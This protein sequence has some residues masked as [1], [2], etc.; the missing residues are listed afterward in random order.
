MH[1]G[2]FPIVLRSNSERGSHCRVLEQ[3]HGK[4]QPGLSQGDERRLSEIA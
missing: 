2:C 4:T 3:A 1:A